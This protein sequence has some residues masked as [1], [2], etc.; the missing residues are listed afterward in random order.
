MKKMAFDM[1][2]N[3]NFGQKSVDINKNSPQRN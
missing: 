2:G 1:D 3:R